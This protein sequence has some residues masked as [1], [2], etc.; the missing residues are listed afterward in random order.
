MMFAVSP[1]IKMTVFDT[2]AACQNKLCKV[3]VYRFLKH[4]A[5]A[6]DEVQ[7]ISKAKCCTL[8]QIS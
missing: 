3:G 8:G 4:R 6:F 7:L 5:A 1:C 2:F